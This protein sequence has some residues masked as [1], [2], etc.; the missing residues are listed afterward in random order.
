METILLIL[1]LMW[2]TTCWPYD[3]ADGNTLMADLSKVL[4]YQNYQILL[5]HCFQII[6]IAHFLNFAGQFTKS[7]F[8]ISLTRYSI[9]IH[10]TFPIR[11]PIELSNS[12]KTPWEHFISLSPPPLNPIRCTLIAPPL[13]H[14]RRIESKQRYRRHRT[15]AK[16]TPSWLAGIR[17]KLRGKL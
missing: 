13:H 6:R 14:I 1:I 10:F 8:I 3:F 15:D 16:L 5:I 2:F 12:N 9:S 17:S 4:Y 7:I 11:A